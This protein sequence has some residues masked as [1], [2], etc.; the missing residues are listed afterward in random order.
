MAP[1]PIIK[2]LDIIESFGSRGFTSFEDV[3]AYFLLLETA[4]E[5]LDDGVIMAISSA[6]HA[7]AQ[8]MHLAESSPFITTVL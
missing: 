1:R 6:T 7:R 5:G 2:H 4:E 8:A 3:S